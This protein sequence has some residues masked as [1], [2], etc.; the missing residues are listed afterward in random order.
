MNTYKAILA[1]ALGLASVSLASAT[2]YIYITG[3][4]ACRGAVYNA[5][6]GGVG[7]AAAPTAIVFGGTTASTASYMEFVT[8]IGTT[9][10]IIK[11]SWSGSE[12]G[13]LDVSGSTEEY[14]LLD[15]GTG[16][17]PANGGVTL[18]TTG[19]SASAP[20]TAYFQ[21]ST[22]NIALADN[23]PAVSKNPS[24]TATFG[25]AGVVVPFVL[26][27]NAGAGLA[28]LGET[29]YSSFTDVT[30][31]QFKV[32]AS[33]GDYLALFTGNPN[34]T[35]TFVYLA[36]RDDNSGT[37]VNTLAITGVG[38]KTGVNQVELTSG[39]LSAYTDEGQSSGGTLAKSLID[40]T[41]PLQTDTISSTS[42]FNVVAYL[43]MA[44]DATAEGASIGAIRL[45]Y[46]G[47]AYSAA[48]VENGVYGIWGY[49][50]IGYKSGS[51][52]NVT[53]LVGALANTTT[54]IANSAYN[55]GY[56]IPNSAMN[57]AR[58]SNLPLNPPVY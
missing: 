49:E 38:V 47:R 34:D 55:D 53:G 48:N 31:D 16:S 42:G 7:Q 27:K 17:I 2:N 41:S 54:G 58:A 11:C 30:S 57:V 29:D 24:T 19:P 56:E 20:D 51:A 25:L 37:R 32:L 26:V 13:T 5:L 10:T 52:A 18:P 45:T 43:G 6:A 36:G 15:P 21:Q 1:A 22:V 12:A 46:N 3:S 40:T 14:F 9:P 39:V 44:D 33:G 23:N 28:A 35:A 4:T 8:T 50:Y